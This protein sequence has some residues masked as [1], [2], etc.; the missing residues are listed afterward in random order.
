MM[1]AISTTSAQD[2]FLLQDQVYL[3]ALRIAIAYLTTAKYFANK[4]IKAR[5]TDEN[6]T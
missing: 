2:Q 4:E 3:T 5:V 6:A 1:I